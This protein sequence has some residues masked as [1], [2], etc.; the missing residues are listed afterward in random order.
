MSKGKKLV[1]MLLL[2]LVF[3]VAYFAVTHFLS[4]DD[5][6]PPAETSDESILIDAL[7][8]DDVEKIHYIYGEEDITLSKREGTWFLEGDDK[9]PVNQ[10]SASELATSAENLMALRL[11]SDTSDCFADYGLA[12]PSVAYVYTLKDAKTVTFFIGDYN[13]FSDSYYLNVQGEEKVYLVPASFVALFEKGRTDLADVE[14]LSEISTEQVR[15]VKWSLDSVLSEIFMSDEGLETV[16]TDSYTWFTDE[17]TPID[18]DKATELAGLL[19]SFKQ[20]GCADYSAGQDELSSYGFD[21]PVFSATID[22]VVS[23]EVETGELD[24]NELPKT[25]TKNTDMTLS[26]IVGGQHN[27]GRY[28]LKCLDS[29]IVYLIDPEYIDNIRSFDLMTLR[30]SDVC[31]IDVE[32]INSMEI[33]YGGKT[34]LIQISHGKDESGNPT[35]E[36]T[37]DGQVLTAVDFYNI[38]SSV[39]SIVSE[40]I[41]DKSVTE[42]EAYITIN[43]KLSREGFADMTLRF[44]PFDRSFYVV[45]F[46]GRCDILVNKRDVENIA[47]SLDN[48]KG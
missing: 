36:Y 8:A 20:S 42:S 40:G 44:I 48:L 41:T 19:V 28:Y 5:S 15:G 21:E 6:V 25:E 46:N 18:T 26:I 16:Y 14:P 3:I 37:L 43:F 17:V 22:Y 32:E 2:I 35:A 1:L 29:D 23:T 47:T 45:D 33:S 31:L 24:V 39:Q 12:Q 11:I 34:R 9:F 13:N 38:Y 10:V 4:E 27:D 30:Y 7:R